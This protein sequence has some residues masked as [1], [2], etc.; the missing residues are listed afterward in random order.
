MRRYRANYWVTLFYNGVVCGIWPAAGVAYIAAV[1][2]DTRASFLPIF[3]LSM[4]LWIPFFM[5][6]FHAF[7]WR[8]R[9]RRK[10]GGQR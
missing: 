2:L 3:V 7:I 1:R 4:C 8:R 5:W 9:L 6:I 10:P